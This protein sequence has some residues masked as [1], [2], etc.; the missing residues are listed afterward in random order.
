MA[1]DDLFNPT[2]TNTDIDLGLGS[3]SPTGVGAALD[4]FTCPWMD[5]NISDAEPDLLE[6]V[7]SPSE[8]DSDDDSDTAELHPILKDPVDDVPLRRE[9]VGV[10]PDDDTSCDA[11]FPEVVKRLQMQLLNGYTPPDHL[12]FEDSRDHLLPKAEELSLKH[13]IAW[14]DSHGTVKA[15]S[16]H[17]QVLQE[18]T[19]IDILSL[20][21]VQKLA[22]ELSGLS[23]QMVNMYSKSCMAFTGEYKD[24]QSCIYMYYKHLGPCGQPCYHKN[25][26][27]RAQMLFIP[28]APVI[29]AYYRNKETAEAM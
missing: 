3:G 19:G 16:L 1:L 10:D 17:A 22:I 9:P 8:Y 12:P 21:L 26:K 15:Y 25:H 11:G 6:G 5:P 14:V 7:S 28:I 24:L 20:Y 13:N 18:A 4:D 29:Q 23:S 2:N 27:L